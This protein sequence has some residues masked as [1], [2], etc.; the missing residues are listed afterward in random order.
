MDV[1]QQELTGTSAIVL[2]HAVAIGTNTIMWKQ[3]ID[4]ASIR[5]EFLVHQ[6]IIHR[7]EITLAK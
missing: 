7:W 5:A 3:V 6:A 1:Q 4:Q 2:F